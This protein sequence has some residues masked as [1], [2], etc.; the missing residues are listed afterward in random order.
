MRKYNTIFY[1]LFILLIMGAFASMAQNSYGLKIMGGVAFVF[2]LVF[3]VEFISVLR[4]KGNRDVY[5]LAEPACL[6]ILSIVFGLRVF[7]IHFSYIEL[8]FSAAG[9]VLALIYLRKMMIRF[10]HYRQRNSFL[11]LLVLLFHSGIILFLVSLTLVPFAPKTSEVTSVVA[12]VLLV[13]FIVAAFIK[14]DLL[15]EGEKI[16]G[17]KMVRKLKDH[18]V[19][20]VSLFLLFSLYLGFNRIGILPGIYSDEFPRAYF[21]LVDKAATKKE[22][23]VD[24]KYRYEAFMKSYQ[25]FLEHNNLKNQ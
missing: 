2:A 8:L 20:I 4:K 12:L 10:R 1:L 15:V 21:E 3:L 16:S 17:F 24:G 7:Y 6:F 25:Q 23:P 14:S 18:S 11:A 9:A 5:T 13:G 19:I 22:K